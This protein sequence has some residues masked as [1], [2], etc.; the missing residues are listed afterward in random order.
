MLVYG[1]RCAS[2]SLAT[3][4]AVVADYYTDYELLVFPAYSRPTFLMNH[5]GTLSP[6]FLNAAKRLVEQP[7]TVQQFDDEDPFVTDEEDA[8]IKAL[9]T[10]PAWYHVPF[11]AKSVVTPHL[12]IN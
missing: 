4:P 2:A 11:L 7:F 1:I 5:G 3:L 12:E 8:V 6:R 9:G 10:S